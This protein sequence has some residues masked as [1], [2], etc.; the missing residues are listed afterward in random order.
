[1]VSEQTHRKTILSLLNL[2]ERFTYKGKGYESDFRV[3]AK[4]YNTACR[5]IELGGVFYFTSGTPVYVKR[6]GHFGGVVE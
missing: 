6:K 2:G 1:M 3:I 5:S 4:G